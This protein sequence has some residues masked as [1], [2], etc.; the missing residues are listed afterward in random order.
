MERDNILDLLYKYKVYFRTKNNIN[1]ISTDILKEIE[2]NIV[3]IYGEG[4][5]SK[6]YDS[7]TKGLA[8]LLP[9]RD[10]KLMQLFIFK[11]KSILEKINVEL[12]IID[13]E[14]ENKNSYT[15]FLDK[16]YRYSEI[17]GNTFQ[18]EGKYTGVNTVWYRS[19]GCNFNCN[20]FGQDNPY[21]QSTWKLDYLNLDVSKYNSMEELPVFKRGC[22][23]S[24]SWSKKFSK[25]SRKGTPKQ[26]VD[27]IEKYLKN[28]Y[29]KSGS[30]LHKK[31]KQWTH[32]AFT[33]G[34]PML[35]QSA[36]LGILLEFIYR[37]N[38]PKYVTIETNGTQMLREDFKKFIKYFYYN[39]DVEERKVVNP[40]LSED[41]EKNNYKKIGPYYP[42]KNEWFWSVSP[43]LSISGEKWEEAIRPDI[44]KDYYKISKNGQLK[45]V[46]N[47][48]ERTWNEVEKAVSLYRD[49]GIDWDVWIMPVGAEK[50]DQEKIQAQIAEE[51]LKRGYY[52]S[53]RVHC[54]VFGNVIG[55]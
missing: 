21:D 8:Y 38:F 23:S 40:I 46:V 4:S 39:V 13:L 32:M 52:V 14:K 36:I 19:W 44:V 16:E 41:Y 10:E 11:S 51:A 5:V 12:V 47:N 9:K 6:Y 55:K 24:Y 42:S 28:E 2:K 49:E 18:G 30:F 27:E 17:F 43:K 26:I 54:W 15:R 33:G 35:N 53:P 37:N 34:E 29:N 31:T 3:S 1:D 7:N 22:D 20:G 25:L 48:D 45:F 50:S